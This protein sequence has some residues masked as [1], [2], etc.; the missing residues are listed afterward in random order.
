MSNDEL[1]I[2]EDKLLGPFFVNPK[3]LTDER[4]ASV[5]KDKVLLYLFE[6]AGKTKRTKMFRKELKTYSQIC[7]AFD[8]KGEW[9]F[10][11]GFDD[12]IVFPD[13]ETDADDS[14]ESQE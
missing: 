4:F 5:F 12:H 8:E 2:N 3:A 14:S 7:E 9:I 1:K 10:G 6:D 13:E 11:S